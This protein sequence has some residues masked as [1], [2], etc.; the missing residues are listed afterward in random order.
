M[1][2]T[3]SPFDG[4]LRT[5]LPPPAP[6]WTG[7][8]P[9]YFVG[10]NNAIEGVPVDEFTAAMARALAREGE[11]L[12]IYNLQSGPLG[13]APLRDWL[14]DQLNDIAGI[15]A[16]ADDILLVSGSLQ[17]IDLINAAM[18]AAGD[19]VVI[20]ED[21]YGGVF[22]RL[23]RLGV[24][25]APVPLD[26]DGMRMDA[27]AE[28]LERLKSQGI[29]PKY[30]YTIPTVQ[31]PT[32]TVLPEDRRREMLRLA[33]AYDVPIFE[34]DCYADL[35]FDGHRPPAVHA[36][37]HEGRVIYLGSFSKSLA[38]AL[39][40]GYVVAPWTVLSRL[41]P[42]KTDAG[43]GALEQ[44]MLA[45]YCPQH[46]KAHVSHVIP[47]LQDK[48]ATLTSALEEHFGT[49]AEFAQ[50]RGGI[51]LWVRLPDAVDTT[52]LA[53][54]A[55]QNGIAINP[56]SEWSVAHDARRSI[57][58]CFANPSK[59]ALRDGIAKLADVCFTEFGVPERGANVQRQV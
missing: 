12:A 4:A 40:V 51:F 36:L 8:P 57:R 22:S 13:Y 53:E 39:R 11:N 1:T 58:I 17:G 21:N 35:V 20:E 54:V 42:L 52:R 23:Q 32:G 25:T 16:S 47:I 31:N 38:P 3:P 55:A 14:K 29:K 2:A 28:T 10:G 59:Q 9:Y 27:L 30:I 24:K 43:S 41:L 26:A 18:L 37:D 46:F 19:T 5:D 49:A 34:D 6:R 44:M 48:L 56:G 7:F 33:A 45:E 15:T 50:P